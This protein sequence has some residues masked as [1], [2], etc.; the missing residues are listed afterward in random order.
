[1]PFGTK[2]RRRMLIPVNETCENFIRFINDITDFENMNDLLM[3]FDMYLDRAYPKISHTFLGHYYA[4]D[5]YGIEIQNRFSRKVYD[6]L[7]NNKVMCKTKKSEFIAIQELNIYPIENLATKVDFLIIFGSL[8]DSERKLLYLLCENL[9]NLYHLLLKQRDRIESLQLSIQADL[10]SQYSHDLN[11][12]VA[13]IT[14]EKISSKQ[15]KYKVEYLEKLM[16]DILQYIRELD[17]F[18]STV[19]M[20]ELL[21]SILSDINLS[22][23]LD[24]RY[25]IE[26]NLGSAT[27]DVELISKAILA[28]IDNAIRAA[29]QRGGKIEL[30]ANKK[31]STSIFFNSSW[32]QIT[33]SDN[34]PGIPSEFLPMITN[35]FFTTFKDRGATG[36]GLSLAQKIIHAHDGLLKIEKNNSSGTRA[37]I[38]LPIDK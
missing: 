4:P 17:I 24:F 7:N 35:P 3:Q 12:F 37:K 33:I 11:S 6:R 23:E 38:F 30:I 20:N 29:D 2:L 14:K 1:M 32:L 36:F 18:K 19:N 22:G 8:S 34:G 28:I 15:I 10:I 25:S 13:L 31:D 5:P 26:N 21:P 16:R 9:Q 27:L